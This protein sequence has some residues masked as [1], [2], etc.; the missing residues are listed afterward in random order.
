MLNHFS[1]SE[2]ACPTTD[3]VRLA[4][5]F[6]EA[7]ERLRVKLDEPIYLN[8]ACRTPLHNAKIN[9]H[10]GSGGCCYGWPI[11]GQAHF[12]GAGSGLVCRLRL[13]LHPPRPTVPLLRVASGRLSLREIIHEFSCVLGAEPRQG[14]INLGRTGWASRRVWR[15]SRAMVG[16]RQ[17]RRCRCGRHSHVR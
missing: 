4:A 13:K 14:T 2:L 8:S 16:D 1:H 9:G 17:C 3:Q 15:Y 10:W 5:G 7:L 12:T 6:G 11:Q